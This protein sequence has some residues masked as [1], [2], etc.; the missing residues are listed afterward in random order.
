MA[1]RG[2]AGRT[3][4]V[5]GAAGGIGS[6]LTARLL[7]EGCKVVAVDLTE[8]AVRQTCPASAADRLH[9]LAADVCLDTGPK[10]FVEAAVRRFEGVDLF[11]N[12]AGIFGKPDSI[13]D[14]PVG[15]FDR[16]M[17]VNARGVFLGLQAVIG[18]MIQQGRGG[19]I[20]NTA[21]A[22]ALRPSLRCAAYGASKS[23]VL[24]LTTVAALENGRH[25]IRVNAICPGFIDTAMLAE[26]TGGFAHK[27]SVKHPI[28]RVGQPSEIASLV[29]FLLSEEASFQ[30]GGIYTVDG[31]MLLT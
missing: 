5:T 12:N 26:A 3:A 16:V 31:G 10:G 22:G 2:L 4:I 13:V 30:T 19:A 6:A 20:V 25:G 23:A 21:S 24:A 1:M 29:A 9:V 8:E 11:F 7:E 15:E 27:A 17:A 28:A 14:M 18:R